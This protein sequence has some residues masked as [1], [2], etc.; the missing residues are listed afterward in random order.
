MKIKIK[1]NCNQGLRPATKVTC[2]FLGYLYVIPSN[3]IE[4]GFS[5]SGTAYLKVTSN[6]KI[7]SATDDYVSIPKF[8]DEEIQAFFEDQYSKSA[9]TVGNTLRKGNFE[10]TLV[11]FGYFTHLEYDIWGDQVTEFRV[12]AKVK[13]IGSEK[14]SLY[15][16]NAVILDDLGG[17]SEATYDSKFDGSDIH[18]GVTKE[19]YFLFEGVNKNAKTLRLIWED[20][21]VWEGITMKAITFEFTMDVTKLGGR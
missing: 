18:P 20:G 12:D 10:V 17:Q 5:D 14:D 7:L 19:G 15:S 21:Y 4:R 1:I 6:G 3:K 13:N 9:I 16:F 11:R 2:T 8:S